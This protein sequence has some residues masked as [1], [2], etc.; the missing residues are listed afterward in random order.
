LCGL[1]W[2]SVGGDQHPVGNCHLV[3]DQGSART[4]ADTPAP[5][6]D[7][8]PRDESDNIATAM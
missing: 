2:L 5:A 3:H 4:S 8:K 7:P 1:H 6:I